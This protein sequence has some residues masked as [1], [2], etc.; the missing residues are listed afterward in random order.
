MGELMTTTTPRAENGAGMPVRTVTIG[1]A[2]RRTA[3][4]LLILFVV[5]WCAAWLLYSSID[6]RLD[7]DLGSTAANAATLPATTSPTA[8]H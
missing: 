3:L 5:I 2:L 7:S 1:W 6:P 4:G 8:Q